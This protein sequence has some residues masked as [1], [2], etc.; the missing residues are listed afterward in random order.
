MKDEYKQHKKMLKSLKRVKS[1]KKG[2]SKKHRGK[3]Q[4]DLLILPPILPRRSMHEGG[5]LNINS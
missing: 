5:V 1:I 3:S 4:K 2:K